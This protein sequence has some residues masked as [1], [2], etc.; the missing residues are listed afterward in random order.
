MPGVTVKGEGGVADEGR[1]FGVPKFHSCGK[2]SIPL[3]NIDS[4]WMLPLACVLF[5]LYYITLHY[6]SL[7]YIIL[8]YSILRGSF[9]LYLGV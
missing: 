1:V 4:D 9:K 3:T 2:C 8:Y 7:Y 5:I 6:I